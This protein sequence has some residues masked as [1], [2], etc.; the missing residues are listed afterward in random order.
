VIAGSGLVY[1]SG[2][3][4][5]CLGVRG[6]CFTS[7]RAL[8]AQLWPALSGDSILD[9]WDVALGSGLAGMA[10]LVLFEFD[11]DVT[12]ILVRGQQI[13]VISD[14]EESGRTIDGRGVRTWVEQ[15]VSHT[16]VIALGDVVL[17]ALP[18]VA[19]MVQAATFHWRR[20]QYEVISSGV[21]AHADPHVAIGPDR[22]SPAPVEQEESESAQ[23]SAAAEVADMDSQ[24]EPPAS[25]PIPQASEQPMSRRP[26]G[27]QSPDQ[28]LEPITGRETTEAQAPAFVNTNFETRVGPLD[29]GYEHL[30]ESTVLRSVEEAAVRPPV[31]ETD[32]LLSRVPSVPSSIRSNELWVEPIAESPASPSR[33]DHDGSTILSG[34]IAVLRAAAENRS[35]A[36]APTKR[37]EL[38]LSTGAAVPIDRPIIIG[39][40]PQA[41]RVTEGSLPHLVTVPSPNGG[42]SRSHVRVAFDGDEIVA[43]DLFSTN[44][45]LIRRADG[46][47]EELAGGRSLVLNVGDVLEFGDDLTADVRQLS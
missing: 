42:I 16:A 47:V 38:V 2:A 26:A 7:D 14:A 13:L 19:G 23:P 43:A 33:G 9:L 39:R 46:R 37:M 36:P 31:E 18:L 28:I 32:G 1:Q 30:F 11:G 12:R 3:A 29:E 10:D 4:F 45:S 20:D 15:A 21:N 44:G 8:A 40:L 22:P 35:P 6:G 27:D 17:P 34:Q 25:T 24:P 41:D 5:L